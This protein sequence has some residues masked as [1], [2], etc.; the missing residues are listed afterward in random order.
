WLAVNMYEEEGLEVVLVPENYEEEFLVK[1]EDNF[2]PKVL[3]QSLDVKAWQSK[4]P[5]SRQ[6]A[7]YICKSNDCRGPFFSLREL[8][9]NL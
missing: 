9:Q 4:L 8:R 7:Y 2:E 3:V 5:G 6:E 1:W